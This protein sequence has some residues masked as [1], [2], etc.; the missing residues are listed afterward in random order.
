MNEKSKVAF[1]VA[2]IIAGLIIMIECIFLFNEYA[3]YIPILV[4]I[5]VCLISIVCVLAVQRRKETIF[6]IT[7]ITLVFGSIAFAI[8]LALLK[9]GAID[10]L[11]NGDS[12][13]DLI[14]KAG[15][16]GPIVYIF[17]QFLQVTFVPIPSTITIIAGMAVFKSLPLVLVCSTIG[18]ISG[19]MFAFFLGRMFGVKLIVWM[20]GS[21]SFNKYQKLLKGRDKMM[22]FLMFLFPIFPDDLLCMFA[23]VMTMSY[24]TFFLMQIITRPIGIIVTSLTVEIVELI[25]LNTWWGMLIWS[26]VAIGMCVLMVL[27]WR[28]SSRLEK[29]MVNIISKHFGTN[30][31]TATIDRLQV[32]NEVQN[33]ISDTVI[34]GDSDTN[35]AMGGT[36]QRYKAKRYFV[37]Y[38][39]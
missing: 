35:I 33:L 5:L 28:Y 31:V 14:K 17:I 11:S 1:S 37:N 24:G 30:E 13:A 6:K 34:E 8:F 16:W 22:L 18:M 23:G 20:V 21:K 15:I 36:K 39:D 7:F 25:P 29:C 32:R 12:L 10:L 26:L 2:A 38:K 27:V 3:V 4:M 9:T 19:S